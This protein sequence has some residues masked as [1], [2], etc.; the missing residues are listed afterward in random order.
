MKPGIYKNIPFD[1]YR[2]WPAVS[3]SMFKHILRS[4]LAL[5]H[6]LDHGEEEKEVMVFGNLADCLLLEPDLF[7]SRY[8]ISPA[9]YPAVVKK[10]TKKDP[11]ETIEDKPWTWTA[12][13]CKEWREIKLRDKPEVKIIS[14]ADVE[15]AQVITERIKGHPDAGEW[16]RNSE[17][18]VSVY[19][20]DPETG[21]ACKSRM[22]AWD[23]RRIIDLKVTN[24]P[25][26][27]AFQRTVNNFKYHAGG[28]FYHDGLLHAMDI[29]PEEGPTVPF[30]FIAAEDCEPYDVVTYDLGPLS[31]EAGRIIY[32]HALNRYKE[33]METEDFTGYSNVTE[34]IE[35]PGYAINKIQLEGRIE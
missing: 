14:P 4:G 29:T 7:E 17:K 5:K 10:A 15:R 1:E 8:I 33:I 27:S 24:D 23:G 31:F 12:N 21:L 35:I 18:Q 11:T 3:K 28:A 2:A 25:L 32:K 9:T 16:V 22:D 30:S 19:W 26:P 34:E 13:Y 6:Y 20:I